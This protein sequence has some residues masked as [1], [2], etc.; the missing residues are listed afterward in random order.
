MYT[1]PGGT[2]FI[3]QNADNKLSFSAGTVVDCYIAGFGAATV[4][5]TESG[6]KKTVEPTVFGV[7]ESFSKIWTGSC[8]LGI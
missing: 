3:T 7:A 6:T 2:R 1:I 8:A 5:I 4:T